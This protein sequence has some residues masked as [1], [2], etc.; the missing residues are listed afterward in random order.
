MPRDERRRPRVGESV[1]SPSTVADPTVSEVLAASPARVE[2]ARICGT[3]VATALST[4]LV[5]SASV[6]A[7]RTRITPGPGAVT[8]FMSFE[9]A[10]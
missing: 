8:I 6:S 5:E 2:T 4:T 7:T 9:T 1:T 10:S 3:M